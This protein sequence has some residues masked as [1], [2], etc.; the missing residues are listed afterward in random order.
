[1]TCEVSFSRA[2]ATFSIVDGDYQGLPRLRHPGVP[3][4]HVERQGV[5][6][7]HRD[8]PRRRRRPRQA[9]DLVGQADLDERAARALGAVLERGRNRAVGGEAAQ[10]LDGSARAGDEL[11]VERNAHPLATADEV[12]HALDAVV[13]VLAQQQALRAELHALGLVGAAAH[14]GPLAALVVDGR[15]PAAVRLDEV[16]LG[17]EPQALGRQRHRPRVQPGRLFD[18]VR[19]R[20]RSAVA[21][22][23]PV[24][25]T[26]LHRVGRVGPFALH[27]LQVGEP[28]AVDVLVDH[29]RRHQ[30]RVSGRVR[31][32]RRRRTFRSGHGGDLPSCR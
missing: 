29:A 1:M 12:Q 28:R 17:D 23:P 27:P 4:L 10:A 13:A 7:G 30:R 11:F 22:D 3:G 31:S 32:R 6:G 9:V 5:G 8:R 19:R 25:V 2:V 20:Q 24:G 21:V 15:H 26:A 16:E 14:V 18:L